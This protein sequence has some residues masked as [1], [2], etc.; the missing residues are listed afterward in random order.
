MMD[1]I[2][3]IGFGGHAKSVIDSIRSTREYELVGYTDIEDKHGALAYLGTDEALKAIY[4]SGTHNVTFGLG[5]MGKSSLRDRLYEH[6]KSIGFNLPVIIDPSASIALDAEIG[7]GTFVGKRAV[8][9]ADSHIGK[10][11][12]I[13][14][15]SIVEHE[16]EIGDFSHIAVG[17]VLCGN[18]KVGDHCLIGANSTVLQGVSV[19]KNSIVGAGSVVLSNVGE[20]VT[21]VGTPAKKGGS[22]YGK[23]NNYR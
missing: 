23:S 11:C 18:V 4:E 10:M 16:N 17:A 9:N 21:V 13:N 20:N 6:V 15:G 3:I 7:E 19:G 22:D 12:I 8:V 1:K 2:V 5:Y 14:T